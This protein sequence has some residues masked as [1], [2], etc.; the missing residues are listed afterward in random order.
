MAEGREPSMPEM[1]TMTSA[2]RTAGRFCT[3]RAS[4][5]SMPRSYNS[6]KRSVDSEKLGTIPPAPPAG[7]VRASPES[8]AGS[9]GESTT[10]GW[11]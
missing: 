6:V 5:E 2:A 8:M 11:Q 7:S 10:D 4:P 9:C 1:T 3:M